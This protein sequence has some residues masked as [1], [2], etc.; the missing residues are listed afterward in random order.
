M[1]EK[2]LVDRS[3]EIANW[4]HKNQLDK[5]SYVLGFVQGIGVGTGPINKKS[6]LELIRVLGDIREELI[7]DLQDPM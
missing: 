7:D 4:N 5:L 2:E 3:Y 6:L 1:T